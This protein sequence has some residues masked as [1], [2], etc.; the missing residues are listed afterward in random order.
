M[1]V[2]NPG[3]TPPDKTPLLIILIIGESGIYDK[4]FHPWSLCPEWVMSGGAFVRWALSGGGFV[5]ALYLN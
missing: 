4:G 3:Q 1:C 5:R 2:S